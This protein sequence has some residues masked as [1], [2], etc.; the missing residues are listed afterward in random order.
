MHDWMGREK[1]KTV[2]FLALK[3]RKLLQK[4]GKVNNAKML[5]RDQV[6]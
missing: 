5:V 4:E 2:W 6:K 1:T 3:G